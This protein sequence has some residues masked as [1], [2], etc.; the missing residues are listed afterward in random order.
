M[1]VDDLRDSLQSFMLAV[2]IDVNNEAKRFTV[3]PA[4]RYANALANDGLAKRFG[5]EIVER[6]PQ[7]L[8]HRHAHHAGMGIGRRRRRG[9]NVLGFVFKKALH[10]GMVPARVEV[11]QLSPRAII[12]GR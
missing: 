9:Q 1:F 2:S 3:P 10:A 12:S 7:V 8:C 6:S 5:P 11:W 4:K